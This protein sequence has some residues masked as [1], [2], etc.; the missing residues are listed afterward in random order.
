M[1][2]KVFLPIVLVVSF[3]TTLVAS[4][5][6]KIARTWTF[7]AV[8]YAALFHNQITIR[9]SPKYF[10]DLI[11]KYRLQDMSPTRQAIIV[12]INNNF[13]L[14]AAAG[15][16]VATAA[17]AGSA[18]KLSLGNMSGYLLGSLA[19]TGLG[20][21]VCGCFN[22]CGAATSKCS[23]A[24]VVNQASCSGAD[25]GAKAFGAVSVLGTVALIVNKRLNS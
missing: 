24:E 8:G 1:F 3:N 18:P 23:S 11:S 10:S 5:W 19:F 16:V 4:E 17:Q 22:G 12:G 14:A 6:L 13:I 2:K 25:F 7:G 15:V 9:L 21:G 20:A